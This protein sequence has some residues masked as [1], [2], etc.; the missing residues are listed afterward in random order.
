MVTIPAVP[1][2]VDLDAANILH[3]ECPAGIPPTEQGGPTRYKLPFQEPELWDRFDWLAVE[4]Q[5]RMSL[6]EKPTIT[7]WYVPV[8]T[9]PGGRLRG[10]ARAVLTTPQGFS[11]EVLP[12][13]VMRFPDV[14]IYAAQRGERGGW[15][16][17]PDIQPGPRYPGFAART[18]PKGNIGEAWPDHK[19]AKQGRAIFRDIDGNEV[20]TKAGTSVRL[21]DG[22][23]VKGF[24]VTGSWLLGGSAPRE[25]FWERIGR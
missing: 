14:L 23:Y 24:T 17:T 12:Y 20:N 25:Y 7:R 16:A 4:L 19:F 1:E 22:V 5:T 3:D 18:Q 8:V 10:Q 15:E 21:S 9:G 6:T 13:D 11:L 2:V